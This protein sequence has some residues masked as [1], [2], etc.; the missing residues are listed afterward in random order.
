[1]HFNSP[2]FINGNTIPCQY[3]YDGDNCSPPLSW[4]SPPNGTVSYVLIVEDPDVSEETFT[5]WIVYNLPFTVKYLPEGVTSKP[6]MP[7]GG[8]QGKNDFGELG[9]VGPCPPNGTHRYLFKL[10]AL[11]ESLFLSPGASKSEVMALMEGHIL[12]SVELM[13]IYGKHKSIRFS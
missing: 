10:Y 7:N 8:V 6:R 11:D 4:D 2:A 1:M 13:G 9:F 12:E 5:H 3:T